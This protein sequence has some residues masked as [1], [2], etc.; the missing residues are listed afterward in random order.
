MRKRLLGI[1][2]V[3]CVVCVIGANSLSVW[4]E[5]TEPTTPPFYPTELV[6]GS[7]EYPALSG[8]APTGRWWY[9]FYPFAISEK[10]AGTYIYGSDYINNLATIA[11]FDYNQFNWNTT[12]QGS[13]R[14][15][16]FGINMVGTNSYVASWGVKFV[17]EG[18]QFIELNAAAVT[19]TYQDLTTTPGQ[20][21]YWSLYQGGVWY[22]DKQNINNTMAVRIGTQSQ[23]TDTSML[24]TSQTVF[25]QSWSNR[26]IYE[27]DEMI[28]VAAEDTPAAYNGK[29]SN[30]K[31]LYTEVQRWT[32]Y[33]GVYVVPEGQTITRFAFASL[34]TEDP[35]SGNLLD[36]IVFRTATVQETTEL[37]IPAT[38]ISINVTGS[39]DSIT[40]SG[41]S[42]QMQAVISPSDA[43]YQT[44]N[45]A[46]EN[47]T[48]SASITQTG[49]L[50]AITNGTV[51]VK[52]TAK[53]GAT[54]IGTKT[55]TISGQ[56]VGVTIKQDVSPMT[57][58][59]FPLV[60]IFGAAGVAMIV[61]AFGLKKKKI[62]A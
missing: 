38:A 36:G 22:T 34:S 44:V 18:N 46:L 26:V 25:D 56:N 27:I 5:S 50:T 51:T 8:N 40:T 52:A 49:L 21:I 39:A 43:T 31:Q 7:F 35:L 57:G 15:F 20:V 14:Y 28:A 59:D 11:G 62:R 6:N 3:V 33:E 61:T 19:A 29:D 60:Y 54:A 53:D 55:I 1:L 10:I 48:G 32:K 41:G 30:K 4:A 17:P 45:W 13:N 12:A 23:L 9:N 16:E 47:G 37:V 2:C 42:I 24:I 58:Q